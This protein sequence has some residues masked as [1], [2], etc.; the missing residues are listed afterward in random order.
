MSLRFLGKK[1]ARHAIKLKMVDYLNAPALPPVPPVFGHIRSNNIDWRMLANDKCGDC[2]W[3]GAAHETIV[4]AVA[5]G[6]PIPNFTDEAIL[7]QYSEQTG[8]RPG[9]DSTD[10]GTDMEAAA[11]YR[12]N[13]GLLDADGVRHKIRA[14]TEISVG[15]ARGFAL[16]LQAVYLFGAAGIGLQ[17]PSSAMD[18]FDAGQPWTVQPRSKNEGGHYVSVVGRNSRGNIM[19]VTWGKLQA[20]TPQFLQNYMDEACCY[21][22]EEYL[23]AQGLS[24]ELIDVARLDADLIKV[25]K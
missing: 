3:A 16:L 23:S 2:V 13:V 18:Q 20:A 22:S 25:R 4:Y 17:L 15:S 12:R 14:Y 11:K 24:P 9:D 5:Q 1:P 21:F 10:Q 19:L 6:R 7:A 8:Y